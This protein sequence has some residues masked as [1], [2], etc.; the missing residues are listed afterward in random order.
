MKRFISSVALLFCAAQL[1][2]SYSF[3]PLHETLQRV[4][5]RMQNQR[6]NYRWYKELW[7]YRYILMVEGAKSAVKFGAIYC[8]FSLV[9]AFL[10]SRE[11]I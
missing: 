1:S 8:G 2:A 5:Q 11:V 4:E 10:I 7:D 9:K 6:R 3:Y